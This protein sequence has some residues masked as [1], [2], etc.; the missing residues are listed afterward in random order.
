MSGGPQTKFFSAPQ[1][2]TVGRLI[3]WAAG[4][5][6]EYG[7]D[8]PRL[9]AE[10]MLAHVLDLD[11]I[12]L[13]LRFDQPLKAEELAGFKKL[14]L[15]RK[16][17]EPVA[18][19]LGQPGVLRPGLLRWARGCLVPRPETEHLVE[20][21]L[22]RLKGL[23]SP[24]VLDLCTGSGAVAAALAHNHSTASGGGG[25]YFSASLGL[26]PPKCYRIGAGGA[27]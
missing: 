20:E 18:Y 19:I 24:R 7:L 21:A 25:G 6:K 8:S 11:R 27:D 1:T 14:L 12:Q 26:R 9:T 15:R 10:L 13:Y 23:D 17:H 22:A 3:G 5:L 2:W 16:A 4:Y